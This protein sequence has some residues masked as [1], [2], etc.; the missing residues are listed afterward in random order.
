MRIRCSGFDTES[1]SISTQGPVSKPPRKNS[2]VKAM[3]DQKAMLEKIGA[4]YFHT[5]ASP[6]KDP[7]NSKPVLTPIW[8]IT[9]IWQWKKWCVPS[10]ATPQVSITVILHAVCELVRAI[11]APPQ[12]ASRHL[13]GYRSMPLPPS[14]ICRAS[15]LVCGFL[16]PAVCS[17]ASIDH[18]HLS[19]FEDAAGDEEGDSLFASPLIQASEAWL[20]L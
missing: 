17:N 3:Q 16:Q 15:L 11:L 20:P 4:E 14:H 9:G 6:Q 5:S 12:L 13:P 10:L 7:H 2:R 1:L 19:I 18:G 8:C